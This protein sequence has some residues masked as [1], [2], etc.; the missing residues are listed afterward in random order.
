MKRIISVM[1][2][3]AAAMTLSAC[4]KE[5]DKKN[6]PTTA[7][8]TGEN[9]VAVNNQS[10]NTAQTNSGEQTMDG[11]RL[12]LLTPYSIY[13]G[14]RVCCTTEEGFYFLESYRRKNY[15]HLMY[16]DYASGQEVFLCSDSSCKHDKESCS[17]VFSHDEFYEVYSG[18]QLFTYGGKLFYLSTAVDKDQSL[19]AV[20]F[21]EDSETDAYESLSAS[22]KAALYRMDLDGSQREK[23]L[24]LGQGELF[25]DNVAGDGD[26]LWLITKTPDVYRDEKTGT[27]CSYSKN[28]QL[29]KFNLTDKKITQTIPLEEYNNIFP[30]F[31]GAAGDKLIFQGVEYP[32]GKKKSEWLEALAPYAD[33]EEEK[34]HIPEKAEFYERC[35]AVCFTMDINT[36]EIKEIFRGQG[37]SA[38]L[39]QRGD[40]LYIGEGKGVLKKTNI[41][42]GESE[43][44]NIPDGYR[45]DGFLLGDKI[46]LRSEDD[47]NL[48]YYCFLDEKTGKIKKSDVVND[49][50]LKLYAETEDLAL[51]S[52]MGGASKYFSEKLALIDLEDVYNGNKDF[53]PIILAER[54]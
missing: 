11:G 30:Y 16:I 4:S 23:I 53:K 19:S 7:W 36:G 13:N 8:D 42:T 10:T 1:L 48:E 37:R 3:F 40:F 6:T 17:A 22:K 14:M 46:A 9:T 34:K 21:E 18:S 25:E 31:I 15:S 38:D 43:D 28:R 26:S 12:T 50:V 41:S 49:L 5:V 32:D 39:R 20:D 29:I 52:Y 24:E 2:I 45:W 35:N 47:A 51:V 33:W 44:I 27:Y 54:G